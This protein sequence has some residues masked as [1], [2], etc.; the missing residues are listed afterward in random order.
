MYR[1]TTPKLIFNV[2]F[3]V[4]YIEVLWVTFKQGSQIKIE[5]Q[6]A[7]C[8]FNTEKNQIIVNLT[9]EETLSLSANKDLNIQIRV[10]FT[11]SKR[12]V[13]RLI[14]TYVDDILHDGVI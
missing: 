9:Q 1:G 8:S 6:L 7:D 13:S 12:A 10:G 2:D 5:K 3:D 4:T 14:T 11:N